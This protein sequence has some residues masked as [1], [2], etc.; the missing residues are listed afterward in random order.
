MRIKDFSKSTLVIWKY[1]TKNTASWLYK[2][3]SETF[4]E[5]SNML[6]GL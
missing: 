1:F 4:D 3:L 2:H 5:F 6:I